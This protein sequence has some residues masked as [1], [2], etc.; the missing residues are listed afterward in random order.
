MLA[1]EGVLTSSRPDVY[2]YAE[3]QHE[4]YEGIYKAIVSRMAL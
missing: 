2:Q 4:E 3:Q 1:R